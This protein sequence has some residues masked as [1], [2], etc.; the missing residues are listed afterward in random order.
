M[1]A[2]LLAGLAALAALSAWSDGAAHA[3]TEG[4]HITEAEWQVQDAPGF[5][6]APPTLASK[7]LPAAWQ[8]VRLPHALPISLLRQAAAAAPGAT[9]TSWFRSR[10]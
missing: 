6:A 1:A 10:Y 2:A 3:H 8:P 4:L 7:T 9:R 5:S